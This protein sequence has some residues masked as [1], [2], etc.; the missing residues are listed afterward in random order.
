[1]ASKTQEIV[2]GIKDT[3]FTRGSKDKQSEEIDEGSLSKLLIP[4]GCT[5]LNLG[6]S[7]N[8]QG[9]FTPGH[10]VNLIGDSSA[11]KTF[12]AFTM[13]ADMAHNSLFDDY[14][15]IYDDVEEANEFDIPRQFGQKLADRLEPPAFITE[16]GVELDKFSDTVQDFQI[17]VDDAIKDGRPFIYVLDSLDALTSRDEQ[18]TVEENLNKIRKGTAPSG[19]YGMDKPKA[20]SQFL[21]LVV[22][23]LKRTKS[24]IL[25][26]SQTRDNISPMAFAQKTRSGGRALKF[27]CSHE[28]WLAEG[29]KE[30]K[31]ERE[32]GK[33][34]YAKITKNKITGKARDVEFPIYNDYGVDDIGACIAFLVQEGIWKSG[35]KSAMTGGTVISGMQEFIGIEKCTRDKLIR[36]IEAQG[37]YKDL[38]ALTEKTWKDIEDS[39]KLGRLSKYPTTDCLQG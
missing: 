6:C 27:Y 29:A 23:K 39:I 37:K 2:D 13:L 36:E 28:I 4:S 3:V 15:L 19:S 21:R 25:V 33:M 11:G 24:F 34:V 14:R 16:D 18:A 32:I 26:V 7:D 9:A 38:V 31:K 8:A 5:I 17:H 12:V 30:K 20:L 22:G 1:M 10:M 35:T